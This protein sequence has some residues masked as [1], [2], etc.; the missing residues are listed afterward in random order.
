[1][2]EYTSSRLCFKADLIEP[3]KDNESFIVRTPNGIFKFTK[4]DFL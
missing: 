1:M 3:L 4:S 2:V